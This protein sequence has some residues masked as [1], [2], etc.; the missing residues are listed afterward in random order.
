MIAVRLMLCIREVKTEQVI[1]RWIAVCCYA[2]TILDC[3]DEEEVEPEGK[4]QD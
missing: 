2:G 1:D 4:A 3:Q